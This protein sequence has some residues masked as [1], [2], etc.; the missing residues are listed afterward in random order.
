MCDSFQTIEYTYENEMAFVEHENPRTPTSGRGT[1]KR[2]FFSV[3][4]VAGLG[5]AI[6]KRDTLFNR[7]TFTIDL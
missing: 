3:A 1:W 7:D 6:S 2:L 5:L 4:L